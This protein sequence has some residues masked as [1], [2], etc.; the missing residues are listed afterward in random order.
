M[1][2]FAK[3]GLYPTLQDT[4]MALNKPELKGIGP[5]TE[6]LRIYNDAKSKHD[7][8]CGAKK[9]PLIVLEGLDGCGK[10]SMGKVLAKKLHIVKHTTPP[11]SI[12]HLR[13]YFDD[14]LMV[15]SAYYSLGNYIAALEIASILR[16]S[17]VIMDRFW[18]STIAFAIGQGIRDKSVSEEERI[19]RQSGRENVTQ[20]E[21]LLKNDL[22]FRKNV[23]L[24]YKFMREPSVVQINAD[25]SFG[26]VLYVLKNECTALIR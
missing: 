7:N 10:T 4:L 20:Q 8:S 9:H 21:L 26:K 18:H 23:I 5:I 19:R 3:F 14:N 22:S 16:D 25:G 15:R 6:L 11:E 12:K 13:S 2:T 24:A 17:P 1:E